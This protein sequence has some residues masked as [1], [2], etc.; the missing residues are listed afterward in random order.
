MKFKVGDIVKYIP[1]EDSANQNVYRIIGIDTQCTD[2]PYFCKGTDG[3]TFW[4]REE[5]L[6][7]VEKDSKERG[8]KMKVFKKEDYAKKLGD[9]R[10]GD[11]FQ[12]LE[13]EDE[14]QY[15][16]ACVVD[17]DVNL[18]YEFGKQ[19]V[20]F[21]NNDWPYYSLVM[22]DKDTVIKKVPGE[23]RVEGD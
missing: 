5:N 11:F 14:G 7:L 1:E 20:I 13:G 4:L 10:T 2:F 9:L 15:G 21:L 17:R 6:A 16:V 22:V 12:I 8:N 3:F 23:I 19:A 18:K